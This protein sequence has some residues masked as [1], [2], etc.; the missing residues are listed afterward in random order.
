MSFETILIP[1]DFSEDS[2]YALQ[3]G[4]LLAKKFN[5]KLLILHVNH[6]ESMLFHYLSD[7]EFEE[8]KQRI[9][10]DVQAQLEKLEEKFPELKDLDYHYR[11]RRGVP[12]VEIVEE[13]EKEKVDLVIVG[14]HGRTSAKK[15]FYGGTT[16]KVARRAKC[17]VMITRKVNK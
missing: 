17:S 10:K 16:S 3:E 15:F 11:I 13:T 5:S 2:L 14:S 6:D 7:E 9:V 8:L 1:V 12:Y 4:I